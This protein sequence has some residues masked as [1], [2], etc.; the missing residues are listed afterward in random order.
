MTDT[1]VGG[2]AYDILFITAH[3]CERNSTVVF[4]ANRGDG[5]AHELSSVGIVVV[6]FCCRF[7]VVGESVV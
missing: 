3:E 1:G 4:L 7:A 5:L 6:E 2:V